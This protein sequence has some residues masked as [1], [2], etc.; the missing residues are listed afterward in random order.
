MKTQTLICLCV[1]ALGQGCAREKSAFQPVDETALPDEKVVKIFSWE[2]YFAPEALEAFEKDTGIRVEYVGFSTTDEMVARLESEPEMFDVIVAD[3]SLIGM[4]KELKVLR[5]IDHSKF[6]NLGNLN[7][8]YLNLDFDTGN[9]YSLPYL[10]GTTGI[11]YREDLIPDPE[12]S[13]S[14]LWDEQYKGKVMMYEE[15]HEAFAAALLKRKADLNSEDVNDLDQAAA[16]LLDQASSMGVRYGDDA[17]VREGLGDGTVWA[18]MCYSGDAYLAAE[19]KNENIRYF[20]PKEG[21]PLWVDSFVISRDTP[22]EEFA[23]AF[24]D[25]MMRPEAAAANANYLWY[26]TP[27]KAAVALLN[28][29]LRADEYIMVPEDVLAKCSYHRILSAERQNRINIAM[30]EVLGIVNRAESAV[31]E[32]SEILR[33][34]GPESGAEEASE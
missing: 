5:R 32:S 30:R 7:E 24:L 2:E 22:H 34:A 13:W 17:D 25:Y 15:R 29:E 12:H 31:I 21:A 8:K 11:G 3:D 9:E 6:K 19:E 14:L 16:D 18:A 26:S 23:Y 28:E 27:N 1:L 4:L 33:G 10:W 20:I